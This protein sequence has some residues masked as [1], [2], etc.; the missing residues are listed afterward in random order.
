MS[1]NCSTRNIIQGYG[2]GVKITTVEFTP[3][4]A[5]ATADGKTIVA[6]PIEFTEIFDRCNG[7]GILRELIVTESRPSS[8]CQKLAMDI[9]LTA[10]NGYSVA[11]NTTTAFIQSVVQ[12]NNITAWLQVASADYKERNS[13]AVARASLVGLP[14]VYNR[15]TT[16]T[17]QRSVWAYF[18]A[19]E[20]K[21]FD[22]STSL[23]V[24]MVVERD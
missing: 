8:T 4:T 3:Y 9:I 14:T 11:T 10:N 18:I 16:E 24:S 1:C 23:I 13:I 6:C 12:Q 20:A 22:A 21:T 7:S 15:S 19:K 2:K 5:G 17:Q